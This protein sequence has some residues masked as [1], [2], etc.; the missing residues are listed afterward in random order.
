[1][2][3]EEN[4]PPIQII[5]IGP[6][7]FAWTEELQSRLAEQTKLAKQCDFGSR[8]EELMNSK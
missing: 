7:S 1:M 4:L 8:D 5:D 2:N 6:A 3:T